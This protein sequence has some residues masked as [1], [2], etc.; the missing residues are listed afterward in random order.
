M[1][2]YE[3]DIKSEWLDYNGHM[4]DA[5]YAI[6]LSQANDTGLDS[7]GIG[8]TYREATGRTMYTVEAHIY[9]QAEVHASD[10]LTA[11]IHVSEVGPKKLRLATELIKK[12][13]D[14]AAR[15]EFLYL[16]YDQKSQAAVP[17][18]QHT[19]NS[20]QKALTA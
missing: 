12:N 11:I 10:H 8:A 1:N 14:V 2:S 13:G 16:H 20:L 18:E 7:F 5:A 19:L 9:Y 17:F 4:N 6:A 3:T 15:G